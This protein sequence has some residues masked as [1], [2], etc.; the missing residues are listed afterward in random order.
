MAAYFLIRMK[1]HSLKIFLANCGLSYVIYFVGIFIDYGLS[2]IVEE[3]TDK[4]DYS[5]DSVTA[6]EWMVNAIHAYN[7]YG[8]VVILILSML[9]SFFVLSRII[10][11]TQNLDSN[12]QRRSPG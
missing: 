8:F 6:N 12:A 10:G 7:D 4:Y 11:K 5:V 3:Y 1:K 9:V 2:T